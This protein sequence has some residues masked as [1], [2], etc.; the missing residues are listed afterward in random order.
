VCAFNSCFCACCGTAFYFVSTSVNAQHAARMTALT[1]QNTRPSHS[2][3]NRN[4]LVRFPT[5]PISAPTT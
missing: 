2:P 1:G 3:G 4:Q 5:D